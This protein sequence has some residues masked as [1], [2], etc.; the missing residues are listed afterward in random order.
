MGV[1]G[2]VWV[3]GCD[4]FVIIHRACIHTES[5]VSRLVITV[6]YPVAQRMTTAPVGENW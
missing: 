6:M 5:N 2:C 4:M 1:L 3:C